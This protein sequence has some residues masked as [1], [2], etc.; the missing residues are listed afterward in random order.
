MKKFAVSAVAAAVTGA[1]LGL[2]PAAASAQGGGTLNAVK[3]RGVLNCGV[4]T[5]LPGFSA[6]DAQGNWTGLDV[7]ICR[8]VAAAVLGDGNKVK[9]FP[10]NAQQRFTALQ[11]GEIDI[12]SRNTSWTLQRD[13]ALGL[14]FAPVTFYDGQGF[15]VAKKLNVKSVKDLNGATVCVQPGTTTELN[16][17]DYFR[18]NRIEFKPVVIQELAEV[19]AAFFSGRCDAYT[20]DASGLASTRAARAQNADDYVIL[21]ELISKEPLAPAVRQG[22]D[23]WGNVVNWTIFALI[24]AEEQSITKANVDEKMKS[25]NPNT[26][27][28][29]GATP[30]MGKNLNLDEAWAANAIKAV[31]NYG[32]IFERNVGKNTPLKLERGLN[33]LWTKGGLMYAM[34]IR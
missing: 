20:T 9:F 16:L 25:D 12:L 28:L 10:L 22:D 4:N 31:G 18:A 6:P 26:K 30:G 29:L 1:V 23:E 5:S 11:S 32:E 33:A 15:M 8:A 14:N 2:M 24:E 17:S 13:T 27:R 34:P 3:Q 7:D 21:P 19:E